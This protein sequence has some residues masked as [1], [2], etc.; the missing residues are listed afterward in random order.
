MSEAGTQAGRGRYA[1]E[2]LSLWVD[3]AEDAELVEEL[4]L[5]ERTRA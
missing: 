4:R 1:R 2:A 5:P 3:D